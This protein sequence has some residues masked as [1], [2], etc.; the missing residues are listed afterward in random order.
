MVLRSLQPGF[1]LCVIVAGKIS[2]K[3]LAVTSESQGER[4]LPVAG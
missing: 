2:V 1:S 4:K 3:P